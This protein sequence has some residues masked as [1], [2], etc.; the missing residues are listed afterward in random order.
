M[1]AALLSRWENNF[2]CQLT[3]F[4]YDRQRNIYSQEYIYILSLYSFFFCVCVCV[5]TALFNGWN[6]TGNITGYIIF[7]GIGFTLGHFTYRTQV[8]GQ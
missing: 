6:S 1:K 2:Q 4:Y 8:L 7:V 5:Y 3:S